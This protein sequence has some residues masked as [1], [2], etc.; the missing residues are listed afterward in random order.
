MRAAVKLELLSS[1][2]VDSL[3]LALARTAERGVRPTII[4]SDNGGNFQAANQLQGEVWHLLRDAADARERAFPH[5]EWHFNPPHAS[6][7]GGVFERLVGS[8]KK[9]L[10]HALP[11]TLLFT[12]EQ[13]QTV[14]ALA[15]GVLKTRPLVY[16]LGGA[17][18]L[19]PLTPN[20]FLYGSASRPMYMFP[21][22]PNRTLA[23]R[24]LLVQEAAAVFW[25]RL[26]KKK[27]EGERLLEG[28]RCGHLLAPY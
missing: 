18:E 25:E 11:A 14:F 2:A 3:L 9:V 27:T 13:L 22:C 19:A 1:L 17:E 10:M 4:L 21:H 23:R 8:V 28:G 24:W 12:T 7:W 5:V 15:E 6:H 26:Q 20:H 16:V